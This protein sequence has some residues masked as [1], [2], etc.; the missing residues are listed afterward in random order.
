MPV[1][2]S[3]ANRAVKAARKLHRRTGRESTGAF[4]VEGPRA[5]AEAEGA[6]TKLFV[7]ESAAADHAALVRQAGADGVEVLTVTERVLASL[8]DTVAPQG[9]VGV[10][11]QAQPALDTVLDAAGFVVV[12]WQVRDPGNVGAVVRTADAAGADG[13]V[14]TSGSVDVR[15]PKA[16]RASA[17]SI[18]HLPIACDA[19][20]DAL[21]AA[22][23]SRGVALVAADGQGPT[24]HTEVDFRRPTALVLGTEA[25]GLP[26]AVTAAADVVAHVPIHGRAESLNLAATAAVLCYEAARQRS[27]TGAPAVTHEEVAR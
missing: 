25:H 10:A 9:M 19:D 16:V 17:G 27:R 23:R 13:V 5:V 15:N 14:T 21:V 3:T 24:P 26:A 20:P 2:G 4:L 22:C 7:T 18:F 12:C 11:E 8:A 6:L 1:I